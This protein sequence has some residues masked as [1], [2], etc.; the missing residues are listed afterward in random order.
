MPEN[1]NMNIKSNLKTIQEK[2][3]AAEKA[4][5]RN[6]RDVKLM[7]VS[8]FHTVEEIKEAID[9]GQLLFGENRV[10]EVC[11][12]FDELFAYK[13][14]IQLHII[15]SLQTNKV[16]NA[17]KYAN[18]IESVDRIELLN[19]IEKQCA[20]INKNIEILM[21]LHTGEES[22]AGFE[23]KE[24]MFTALDLIAGGKYPHI[25]PK[26]FMTMAP[27][28]ENKTLIEKS[29]KELKKVSDEAKIKYPDFDLCELSMGMSADFE[30]A[31]AQGSTMVRVGTA[32]FGE[33]DYSK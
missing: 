14:E 13:P 17:V 26:G 23:T 20:K 7:A 19:E 10:Q 22:K 1:R 33:R 24:E 4:S 12:K 32:I 18:C 5:G 16:K 28:T 21:E 27:F 3:S 11:Q 2:I 6:S 30:L 8:K 9:A 25:T 15:G 31:I 29:F